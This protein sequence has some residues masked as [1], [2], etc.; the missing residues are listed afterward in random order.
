MPGRAGPKGKG[1]TVIF[2]ARNALDLLHQAHAVLCLGEKKMMSQFTPSMDQRCPLSQLVHQAQTGNRQAFGE[3][4]ERYQR[5]VFATALRRLGDYTEAQ[6]LCQDVFIQALT[7]LSQLRDPGCFGSWLRSIAR[8]MA[9]N[10][11]VRRAPIVTT[12]PEM[13][14]ATCTETRTPLTHALARERDERLHAGLRRLGDLDRETLLAFYIRGQ[15]L[16]EM[17][18]H[19]DAPVGTIKR[20][21][22]V[23]RKRLSKEVEGLMSA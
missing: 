19:F 23:A 5:Q 17:S 14:E 3:L 7:K 13:L 9:I 20:R 8:R 12:E 18:D 2:A 15:S 4:F 6:E 16:V 11:M 1:G 21:L 10:R 22:H